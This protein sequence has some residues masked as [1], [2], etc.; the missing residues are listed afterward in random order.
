MSREEHLK[1]SSGI[2]VRCAVITLSDTRNESTDKSGQAIKDLLVGAGNEVSRYHII[3]DEPVELKK[4]LDELLSAATVDAI[5]TNGGT[6]ISRRDQTISVVEKNIERDLPG[7]G[8]LFRMLSFE[9]VGAAAMLSRACA[10]IA[11]R[12]VIF[13]LPGSEAAVTLA[14]DRLIVPE[15]SHVIRELRR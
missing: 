3:R 6:G 2:V 15:L 5:L 1:A 12:L 7:F 8:E 11:G 10:G 14:M 9:Q 4:L 13:T